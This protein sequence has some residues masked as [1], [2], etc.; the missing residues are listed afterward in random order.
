WLAEQPRA[1]VRLLGVGVSSLS[2]AVQLDLFGEPAGASAGEAVPH[3]PARA[4]AKLDPTLDR[5]R[6]KFGSGAVQRAS[7]LEKPEKQDGFTEVR[8]RH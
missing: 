3:P 5:I 6:E 8:R 4:T 1:A 7:T 2:P